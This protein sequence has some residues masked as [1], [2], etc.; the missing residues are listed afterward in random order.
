MSIAAAC[1][2]VLRAARFEAM[3]IVLNRMTEDIPEEVR[4][5]ACH[6]R[7]YHLTQLE[8]MLCLVDT[9]VMCTTMTDA[10]GSGRAASGEVACVVTLCSGLILAGAR[11][12]RGCSYCSVA[13]APSGGVCVASWAVSKLAQMPLRSPRPMLA[14]CPSPLPPISPR[15]FPIT[16]HIHSS[17]SM[18]QYG[19]WFVM[20]KQWVQVAAVC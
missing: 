6:C 8:H 9:K 20:M 11:G 7:M 16:T 3:S 19:L 14:V 17:D 1:V 5:Y 12:L 18:W 13:S 4:K 15:P 2:H 10:V